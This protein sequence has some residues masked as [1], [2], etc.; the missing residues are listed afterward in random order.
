MEALTILNNN[1]T[2]SL[3]PSSFAVNCREPDDENYS[4]STTSTLG[5]SAPTSLG[6][7]GV[8]I[9]SS[10]MMMTEYD[11]IGHYPTTTTQNT[12]TG[13]GVGVLP[14]P[15]SSTGASSSSSVRQSP[16]IQVVHEPSEEEETSAAPS[17][18][19][20]SAKPPSSAQTTNTIPFPG[21]KP[22]T[23]TNTTT[24]PEEEEEEVS[25]LLYSTIN[26]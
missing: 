12:T 13:V 21:A 5:D 9:G 20:C 17:M 11:V 15:P 18:S 25:Y 7:T 4:I 24:L 2:R 14:P 6:A 8:G 3:S 26:R 16:V 10:G 23:N 22:I 19:C 1:E